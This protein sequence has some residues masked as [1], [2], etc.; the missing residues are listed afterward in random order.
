M[1]EDPH[2][3]SVADVGKFLEGLELG[4]LAPKFKENAVDGKGVF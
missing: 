4:S 1:A 2:V 3:W